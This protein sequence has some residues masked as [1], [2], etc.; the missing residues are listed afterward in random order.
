MK[1]YYSFFAILITI[2]C[3]SSLKGQDTIFKKPI[4]LSN[5]TITDKK[6]EDSL[7]KISSSSFLDKKILN[8][9]SYNSV[10]EAAKFI[11]GLNVK[12]YGG[13][14]G[15]KTISA[16]G[17]S[18]LHSAVVLDGVPINDMQNGTIDLGKFSLHSAERISFFNGASFSLL[19]SARALSSA[20]IL[21]IESLPPTFENNKPYLLNIRSSYGSFNYFSFGADL[22]NRINNILSSKL[23]INLNNCAGNYPFL[24]H[25]GYNAEDSSSKERRK[26]ADYLSLQASWD[27]FLSFNS[28]TDVKLKTYYFYSQRGLPKSTTLYYLNS[29]Q[30]LWDENIFVQGVLNHKFN[31]RIEYRSMAKINYLSTIFYDGFA[32]NY[33]GFQR[34][35]Y[36]QREYFL[37]NAFSYRITSLAFLSFGNDLIYNN[38]NSS[39][40]YYKTPSRFSAISYI[41]FLFENSGFTLN[42]NLIHNHIEDFLNPQTLNKVSNRLSPYILIGYSF[43]NNFNIS[44]FYKDI[45]RSP[46]FNELYFN[47]VLPSELSA[48]KAKQ[49][50]LHLSYLK[51]FDK[52]KKN[53][54]SISIDAYYNEVRDKIVAVSQKNLF[55]WS[56][57]N[58][59]KVDIK[60]VDLQTSF[61]YSLPFS[62]DIFLRGV[63]AFQKARDITDKT[64][65]TYNNQIPYT[66]INSGSLFVLINHPI[67]SLSYSINFVGK[68]YAIAENIVQNLLKPYND[69]SISIEKTFKIKNNKLNLSLSC[70][71][72][73]DAQYEVVKNYP[74]PQRQFRINLK[75]NF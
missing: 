8:N 45:F 21:F 31:D 22:S 63:Y 33:E 1:T 47:R 68:R 44:F 36:F 75:I 69:H 66:P 59:G 62:F 52:E 23:D 41:N 67:A 60:G 13:L 56:I 5:V 49:Y 18:S 4:K 48:E 6:S 7:F 70:L 17:F 38:L 50:N 40:T 42:T 14:G 34:D 24:L 71:N 16:R 39:A 3:F 53:N 35:K 73:F 54:I 51:Y 11:A 28:K 64:L 12:D 26:N 37:N 65:K 29:S 32:L 43:K 58:F 46:T 57:V 27:L 15:I 74:M 20:N 19:Q 25:Y 10:G 72:I 30:R 55:I 9:V 61:S 2:F